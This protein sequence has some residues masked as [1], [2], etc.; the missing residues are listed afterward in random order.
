LFTNSQNSAKFT[1]EVALRLVDRRYK[2]RLRIEGFAAREAIL[3][4]LDFNGGIVEL[5]N[6]WEVTPETQTYLDW[7]VRA[8]TA[9]GQLPVEQ[10]FV[11]GVGDR[12]G[13]LLRGHAVHEEGHYGRAPMGTDF[14]LANLDLERRILGI[15]LFNALNISV[16]T[17]KWE[18]F[19]DAAKTFD[20]A[21]IFQQGKLW[22]DAGAGLR[23]ETFSH[24]FTLV[25]GRSLRD[26]TGAFTGYVERRFW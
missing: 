23:L 19:V 8:G 24:S 15:P 21:R 20:R 26:G 18:L 1:A 14:V 4:D 11:V 13:N 16:L 7:T 5:A 3:G 9:R 12:S 6:R 25:Y 17:V 10:Y 22:V 2:N